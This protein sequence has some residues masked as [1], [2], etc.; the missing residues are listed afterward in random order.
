MIAVPTDTIYGVAALAQDSGAVT[1]LFN[2]KRRNISKAVA[3]SVG[4]IEDVYK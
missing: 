2:V 4:D 1:K 3:I